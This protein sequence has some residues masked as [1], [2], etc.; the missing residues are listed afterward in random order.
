MRR[1]NWK[2]LAL[3]ALLIALLIVVVSCLVKPD[4]TVELTPTEPVSVILP[5]ATPSASPSPEPGGTGGG[6][7][8]QTWGGATAPIITYAPATATQT[9]TVIT[10]TPSPKPSATPTP[11]PSA[12]DDGTLRNGSSG[13]K[14]RELQQRLKDLG[15]YTG[16]VD[17]SFGS[18]TETALRTFQQ[19]NGLTVDGVAGKNTL[20]QLNSSNAKPL[21][22]TAPTSFYAT[23]RPTPLTYTPSTPSTYKTLQLGSSRSEVT[24]LQNRLK[25][26][27]YYSGSVTGQYDQATMDAVTAFQQRNGQWVDGVAGED[28]QRALYSSAALPFGSTKVQAT[29]SAYRTLK[30]DMSGDDVKQLQAR[31]Q[32]LYYYNG[33]LDGKYGTT[34]ELAV[35]V[36]QQRNGLTVDG[37]AGSGTQTKLYSSGA[38]YAPTAQ[39]SP[40][41]YKSSGTLEL[42]STGEAVVMLQEKLYELGYYNGKID[43]IYSADVATAVRAFQRK[44]EL[45]S[46][47]KAG[48]STQSRLYSTRAIASTVTVDDTFTTLRE[49]DTGERVRAMQTLLSTYGY[50][51]GTVDGKY[52]TATTTA[53]Q[54]FQGTNGLTADG[55]AGP[56]TLQLLYQG[57]PKYAVVSTETQQTATFITLK[58]GMTGNDVM[59]MQQYLQDLGYYPYALDGNFGQTTSA[60][61]SAFQQRNGLTA[62]GVAGQDTLALLYSGDGVAAQTVAQVQQNT[63]RTSVK[64]G[65][66]GQDVFDLQQRLVELKYFTGTPD[67]IFG[68]STE[69]ALKAFQT[70]NG[71]TSDGVAGQATKAAMYAVGVLAAGADGLDA[72]SLGA[73]SN[74][75]R[76]LE[77]QKVSGAIQGSLMGGGVAASLGS[78]VYF[79][80]GSKGTLY[81]SSGGTDKQLYN[82]PAS[83]IHATDKGIT[84]VSGSKVLRVSASGGTAQTLIEAGGITKLSMLGETMYYQEG[85]SLV[86]ALSSQDAT[87]VA[88]GIND[89][90]VDVYEYVAYLATDTGVKRVSLTGGDETLLVAT[91]ANQVQ[92]CDSIVFFRSGGGVYRIENGVS[93]L[94]I[95]D[96]VSWMSIYR[97]KLYYISGDRLYRCDTNGQNSHIFYD[98]LTADVSF[99]SG[100]VYITKNAGGPVVEVMAVE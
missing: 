30:L 10:P 59:V 72:S 40:T 29:S 65:D 81:V 19:N 53:V 66:Q 35:K 49:G 44:N 26:L 80:G 13:Q 15:Y 17:G 68:A 1:A 76:E 47:G 51:T 16:S 100:K 98:G 64:K 70:T 61:L 92:V 23:S 60:A 78:N 46:D 39:P 4:S 91:V 5:F 21:V 34:T 75:V 54:Q 3:V 8:L 36:F 97:D 31:L 90:A 69:A 87:V 71:L 14:V 96:D 82:A 6:D 43:G 2:W 25:E 62:D 33:S 9:M 45:T 11:K 12:T 74:R 89:F 84:F 77:E 42:G 24:P 55:I 18:G 57:S 7:G 73:V 86:R 88:T 50:F 83:F 37:I 67:G 28:T 94:L 27:G 20:T 99:V 95:A 63:N 52:S 22:T 93:V 56:A 48:A 32:A 85:S 58:Q 79:S 38:L 41:P